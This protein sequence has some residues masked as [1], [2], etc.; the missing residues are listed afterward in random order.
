MVGGLTSHG[1]GLIVP[2]NSEGPEE[3]HMACGIFPKVSR[4]TFDNYLWGSEEKIIKKY[5][6]TSQQKFEFEKRFGTSKFLK[7]AKIS[8]LAVGAIVL[9]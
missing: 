7:T 2:A 4:A 5:Q 9:I 6:G 3:G 8:F 1:G